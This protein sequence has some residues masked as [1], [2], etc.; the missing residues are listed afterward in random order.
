MSRRT[1]DDEWDDDDADWRDSI[2][3]DDSDSEGSTVPCPH[4]NRPIPEDVLRCPY[5]GN[6]ISD[7]DA[8]PARKPWWIIV[9]VLACLY[10]IY[11]W[12]T[13]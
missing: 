2:D 5:C 3:D 8:P 6:Y 4:C 1:M 13:G 10:I 12:T 7:E 11:R 9:G